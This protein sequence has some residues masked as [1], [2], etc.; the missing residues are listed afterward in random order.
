M[1]LRIPLANGTT[2]HVEILGTT[3]M[4]TSLPLSYVFYITNFPV[5]LLS[6]SKLTKF[7]NSLNYSVMFF[8]NH[9]TFQEIVTQKKFSIGSEF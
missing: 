6:I 9:P 7:L 8:P 5:N 2:S 1:S 3:T 4:A